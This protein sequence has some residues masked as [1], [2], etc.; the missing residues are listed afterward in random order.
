MHRGSRPS[1]TLVDG[2]PRG[3]NASS[4]GHDHVG[5]RRLFGDPVTSGEETGTDPDRPPA[6]AGTGDGAS[7]SEAPS[8]A[9]IP[10]AS[11]EAVPS[12]ASPGPDLAGV[13]TPAT[14]PTGARPVTDPDSAPDVSDLPPHS[15]A[16]VERPQMTRRRR[17]RRRI[18]WS[19]LVV[20]VVVLVAA[21]LLVDQRINR[22]VAQPTIPSGRSTTLVVPG[23][24]PSPPWPSSGQAAVEIPSLGY[25]Q[26]SSL[27][28]PVPI[29]SLAKIATAVVILRDHPLADNTSGPTITVTPDEANQF[30]VDLENDETNIPLQTGE[31]LTEQQLLEGLL[32]QSA[33]DAAYTLAVWDAGSETAFV[34]KMNALAS[35]LGADETH[36]ADASGFD[37]ASVSTAA[38]MLRFAAAGMAIPAF[39]AVVAMP[40]ANLPLAGVIHN[41]VKL[42]GTDG[43]VGVKSGYTSQAAGCMVLAAYRAI[44]G[45]SVLVLASALAQSEP[46]PPAPPPP[47]TVPPTTTTTTPV[48]STTTTAPAPYSAIEA[49]YP[50]LYTGPIVERLLDTS[51]AAIVAVPAVAKGSVVRMA[52]VDW[53]G[54]HREVP[55]VATRSAVLVGLPGQRVAVTT[56]AAPA[57]QTTG[58]GVQAGTVRFMLGHEAVTVPL[59]LVHRV[60]QPTWWWKALH[61]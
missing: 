18:L 37:P 8:P 10:T 21:G 40:T 51:E 43:I 46:P 49:Q 55:A 39:A 32:I 57:T 35:S 24:A 53:G 17:R 25:A 1:S 44:E 41:V 54:I 15:T 47:A 11:L 60:A 58:S 19:L 42:I 56:A 20:V 50:L 31:T 26:Q 45:R 4:E 48:P 36:Y 23:T 14:E 22:P 6:D 3:A 59:R 2:G 33:N 9:A 52:S 61:N 12:V 34:A 13:V 28:G 30:D 16:P 38:D 29:A 27:E 5:K 7:T